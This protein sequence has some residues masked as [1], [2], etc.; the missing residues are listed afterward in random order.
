M[1]DLLGKWSVRI[2]GKNFD[3]DILLTHDVFLGLLAIGTRL[4]SAAE[5]ATP[6]AS[7]VDELPPFIGEERH[8][9]YDNVS[10]FTR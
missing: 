1:A 4:D 8:P 7:T 3:V 5:C 9:N 2:S 6:I 10:V